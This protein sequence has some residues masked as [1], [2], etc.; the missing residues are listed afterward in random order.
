MLL[1]NGN[2]YQQ[3]IYLTSANKVSTSIYETVSGV[4][5]YFNLKR[6]NREL[7]SRIASLENDVLNLQEKLKYYD[8]LLPDDSIGIINNHPIRFDYI[9]ATVVNNNI[10]HP[11]NYFTINKGAEDGITPGMGVVDRNGI[12]GIVNVVGHRSARIISVLNISQ[13]FSVKV[14][15]SNCI[16]SLLWRTGNPEIAY[17]EEM[18]RHVKYHVGDTIVTSGYSTT[19]PEGIPVGTIISQIHATDDNFLTLKIHLSTDFKRLSTVR[20]IK[21]SFM[22]ELDSLQLYDTP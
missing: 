9:T 14:K 1:F 17:V 10:N 18:P 13:H 19:F 12:A 15:D 21:D 7:Q 22:Q 2:D 11:R 20:I 3:S 5:E 8:T 16:G 4:N 6:I